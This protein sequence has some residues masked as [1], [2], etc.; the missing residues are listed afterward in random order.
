MGVIVTL[1][2]VL[3]V[4]LLIAATRKKHGVQASYPFSEVLP[5]PN[6]PHVRTIHTKIRGV[7]KSNPDGMSRQEI[8][9]SRCHAGNALC[10]VRERDNPVD[11]N[12]V[13][14]RRI[15]RMEPDK[16]RL[17]EQ[18]GY[19]S[20][21]LAEDLAPLLDRGMVVMLAQILNV[22]GENRE[23]LGVNIQIEEYKPAGP[24]RKKKS[25]TV[26][27]KPRKTA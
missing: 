25:K 11:S 6:F 15:V 21:E 9:R 3:L 17:G 8:I 24:A 13:Q 16:P 12:A 2:I 23:T 14:V 19:V 4:G 5:D 1:L 10:L 18:L 26:T 20:R 22:T 7:S 27:R